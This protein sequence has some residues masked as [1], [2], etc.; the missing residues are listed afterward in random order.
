[1]IGNGY[2]NDE[3]NNQDCKYDGGDCCVNVNTE[4]CSKCQCLGGGVITSP[5]FPETYAHNL[6]ET[7]LIEVPSGQFIEISFVTFEIEPH[8]SCK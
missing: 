5:G 3:T 1:M 4:H 6:E 2:C 8:S 7:W